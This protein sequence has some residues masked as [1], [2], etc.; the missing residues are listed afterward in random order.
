MGLPVI[1][2]TQAEA[3]RLVGST[4]MYVA[5]AAT[6]INA[7]TPDLINHV[8][9]GHVP[10]LEAAESVRKRVQLVQAYREADQDDRKALGAA[11]G[12]DHLFDEA[13]A[14]LL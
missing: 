3:A 9:R 2:G 12:V 5:A 7:E 4:S 14:P 1:P 6:V 11:V 13:I 10:L 8:L